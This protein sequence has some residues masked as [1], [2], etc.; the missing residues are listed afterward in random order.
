[1]NYLYT[2]SNIDNAK[3]IN[4]GLNDREGTAFFIY[5]EDITPGMKCVSE[6]GTDKIEV[7]TIDGLYIF[8]IICLLT[9]M[10]KE[11]SC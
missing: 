6:N 5:K 9:L 2:N 11:V 8:A 7:T 10:L 3:C 4:K 1:M